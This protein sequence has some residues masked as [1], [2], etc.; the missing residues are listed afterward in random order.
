M[1][2]KSG[3]V[4]RSSQKSSSSTQ[5]G[6]IRQR[7]GKVSFGPRIRTG[8][9]LSYTSVTPCSPKRRG[10][11]RYTRKGDCHLTDHSRTSALAPATPPI[12][13]ISVT[14]IGPSA[15]R[16][17]VISKKCPVNI[18]IIASKCPIKK[19]MLTCMQLIFHRFQVALRQ[20]AC[21][22]PAQHCCQ[23]RPDADFFSL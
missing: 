10:T 12:R 1:Q 22:R 3:E 23:T 19:N 4:D 18:E 17:S 7:A 20:P 9:G 14:V 6:R 2:P 5:R 16:Q 13:A 15:V 21:P 8:Q 11:Q